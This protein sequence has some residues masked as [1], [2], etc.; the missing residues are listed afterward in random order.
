[1]KTLE[2]Q[3][4]NPRIVFASYYSGV[5]ESEH[6]QLEKRNIY[7]YEIELIT[8]V[9]DGYMT[10]DDHIVHIEKGDIIFRRPNESTQG[11]NRYNSYVVC[12]E[13]A[14]S[15]RQ[16]KDGYYLDQEKS[17]QPTYNHQLIN[18]LPR[19]YHTNYAKPY[20]ESFR[21]ILNHFV[22]ESKFSYFHAKSQLLD[23]LYHLNMELNQVIDHSHPKTHTIKDIIQYIDH[24][25]SESLSLE[26]IAKKAKL[27][28]IYFHQLFKS[29]TGITPNKYI[30][31]KRINY[32]K[33]LLINSDHSIKY[34]CHHTGFHNP[35]YF[36]STFKKI[37]GMTPSSFRDTNRRPF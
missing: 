19:K 9:I 4:F 32:A 16:F 25:L 31:T 8:D 37:T 10:I 15:N 14:P 5:L 34:I 18:D 12:F 1:M 27:S 13:C 28:P 11:F 17:Y 30:M 36:G 24:H 29:I 23:I 26:S 2:L 21:I 6:K 33:E 7:D 22:N 3:A 35:S 20:E